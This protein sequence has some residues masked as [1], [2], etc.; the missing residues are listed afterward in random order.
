MSRYPSVLGEIETLDLVLSGVSLARYGDGE[1]AL[2]AERGIPCQRFDPRLSDRLREILHRPGDCAVGVPNIRSATP[3]AAYWY[4]YERSARFYWNRDY[5]SAFVTRPDSAPWI[6]T[7]EYWAKVEQ[8]W[9]GQHVTLVR[10]GKRSF[11]ADD[12]VGAAS[13]N[14]IIAPR[15]HA[16]ADYVELMELIGTPQRVLLC[17]G[18]TAT[19]MAVDLCAKG[20]H[21]IDAGHLGMFYRKHLQGLP[22]VVT[23][24]DKAA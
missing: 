8:L 20:V 11:T 16:W 1:L 3:K 15:E 7:P 22:M 13:V 18:P 21:A 10:G 14:E 19:V 6:D 5:V 2:C 17:L 23:D 9:V 24:E 12:L 4:K